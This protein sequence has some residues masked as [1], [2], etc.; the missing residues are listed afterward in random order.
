M[1]GFDFDL[2]YH[3]PLFGS[4][5]TRKVVLFHYNTKH[6]IVRCVQEILVLHE[7]INH[8]FTKLY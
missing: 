1:A 8:A 7:T 3:F 4:R 2:H 6:K 5:D